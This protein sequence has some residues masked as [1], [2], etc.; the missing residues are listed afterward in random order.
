[1][2]KGNKGEWSEFYTFL[3]IV[4]EKKLKAADKD[5]RVIE[6]IFYPVIKIIR[7]EIGEPSKTYNL[8]TRNDSEV[9]ILSSDGTSSTV[10]TLSLPEKTKKIFEI[11]KNSRQRSFSI[12][13]ADE[14]MKTFSCKKI[15]VASGSKADIKLVIHDPK[16][17]TDPNVGFSIKSKIG[18]PSTLLNPSKATNFVFKIIDSNLEDSAALEHSTGTV[19]LRDAARNSYKSGKFLKLEFEKVDSEIFDQNMRK[20]DTILPEII[21]ELLKASYVFGIETRLSELVE[22]VSENVKEIRGFSMTKSGYEHKVKNFLWSIALGMVPNTLWD[23]ISTV[24]GGYIIVREDGEI[25]CYH[26]YNFDEFRDYLYMNTLLDTPS[27]SR[28]HFGSIYEQDG[29]KKIKYNLQI[30]FIR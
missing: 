22:F 15:K 11:I 2:I 4:S 25:V 19:L 12:D 16:T 8:N 17:G 26:V 27:T 3:K 18:S 7:E 13:T 6:D 21:A 30:R 29:L 23:G 9:E 28:Y 10:S 14:L 24:H 5:L 20:V 1:M